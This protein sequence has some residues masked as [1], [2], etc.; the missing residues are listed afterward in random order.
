MNCCLVAYFPDAAD[1]PVI[2]Q[3]ISSAKMLVTY[4]VPSAQERNASVTM[5]RLDLTQ[6]SS[7]LG[8]GVPARPA[9]G[10]DG[11]GPEAGAP[12]NA[13]SWLPL[14][15]AVCHVAVR[16]LVSLRSRLS[17]STSFAR[18]ALHADT[19]GAPPRASNR[20]EERALA[21]CITVP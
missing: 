10:R 9:Y 15:D 11:A 8:A 1:L 7:F 6:V 2:S 12:M 16:E 19:S 5:S 4:P 21:R 18:R 20:A 13:Q 3:V 17:A 14:L